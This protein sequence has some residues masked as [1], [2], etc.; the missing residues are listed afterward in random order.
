MRNATEARVSGSDLERFA[1]GVYG[2]EGVS[3]ACLLLQESVGLDVNLLLFAAHF[4]AEKGRILT[5]SHIDVLRGRIDPWHAE[6]VRPLRVVRKRL[7][8]GPAPAPDARTAELRSALQRLE[9]Q[10]ELIELA[11]LKVVG[12]TLEAEPA[13]GTTAARAAAA[14]DVVVR[15]EIDREQDSD[16]RAAAARIATAAAAFVDNTTRVST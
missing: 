11:E 5:P 10:A 6:V 13:I 2:A 3:S 1:L 14:I 7:K 9:I 12:D 15:A 16:E 8:S 4:G